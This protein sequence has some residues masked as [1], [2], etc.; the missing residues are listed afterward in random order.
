MTWR[1]IATVYLKELR[2]SLR[3]RR[4]LI[5]VIVVPTFVMPLLFLL[6]GKV[7]AS[8]VAKARED[9]PT[10][11]LIGGQDSP[12]ILA[13][14][15]AAKG[16][17]VTDA[18]AG[19]RSAIADKTLRVAV[20]IPD[21]FAARLEAGEAPAVRI[22][23]YQAE[24][25]SENGVRVVERFLADLREDLVAKRL[26]AAGLPRAFFATVHRWRYAVADPPLAIGAI[27]TDR[28][29]LCG[30]WCK[31]SRIEDAYL[32]GLEAASLIPDP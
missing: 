26:A 19:W 13:R 5:S 11:A 30:D 16:M 31:G 14:F 2:D 12:E 18:P 9:V 6:V 22:Y 24:L 1:N 29:I 8:S 21:R 15:R 23:H 4:T 20:E 28:V 7:T 32:S 10:V 27:R 17:R 25:K 3:D